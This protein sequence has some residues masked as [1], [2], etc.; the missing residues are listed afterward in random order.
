LTVTPPCSACA[1]DE[2]TG[3]GGQ[4]LHECALGDDEQGRAVLAESHRRRDGWRPPDRMVAFCAWH[5]ASGDEFRA[6]AGIKSEE[7]DGGL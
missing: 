2:P 7:P 3:D 1:P 6:L 5:S 4:Q